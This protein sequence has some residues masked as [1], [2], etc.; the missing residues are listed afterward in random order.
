MRVVTIVIFG[1]IVFI[2]LNPKMEKQRTSDPAIVAVNLS[3]QVKPLRHHSV[4]Y[5]CIINERTNDS[6]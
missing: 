5:T 6:S 2:Y 4:K 3:G 1:T